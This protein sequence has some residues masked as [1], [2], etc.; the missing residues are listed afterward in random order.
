MR[1]LSLTVLLVLA[2]LMAAS[3]AL[4]AYLNY[5]SVRNT[6]VTMV[7]ERMEVVARRIAG[8][9]QVALGFGLPLAGQDALS[10]TLAREAEADPVI[11]SV[12]VVA[13][14]GEVLFSSDAARVGLVDL[15]A[16]DAEAERRSATILS[17]F[18]T[19]EGTVVVRGSRAIIAAALADLA[20]PI[21]TA[22]LVAFAAGLALI[23][24]IV[25]LNTRSL[26]GRLQRVATQHGREMPEEVV[27]VFARI[28]AEH[29]AIAA[30]ADGRGFAARMG[31]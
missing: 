24:A 23:A 31:G 15:A 25:A 10:R 11:L 19:T 29:R 16:A 4:G 26:V 12:D 2:P 20:R 3:L 5:A 27:P 21:R 28:D 22:A 1:R 14:S 17:A 18:E 6:Y 13:S 8:D 30:R 9:A 7:G